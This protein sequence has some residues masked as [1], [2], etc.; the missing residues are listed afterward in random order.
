MSFNCRELA[1]QTQRS[2]FKSPT[3]Y[4]SQVWL[5]V[6]LQPQYWEAERR[7]GFSQRPRVQ[8]MDGG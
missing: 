8:G 2:E 1:M 4:Q 6:I 5:H 3:L 7:S